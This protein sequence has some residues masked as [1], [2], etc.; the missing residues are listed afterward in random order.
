MAA[1]L[2]KKAEI[3]ARVVGSDINITVFILNE[4]VQLFSIALVGVVS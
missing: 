2:C 3:S 4:D 1:M